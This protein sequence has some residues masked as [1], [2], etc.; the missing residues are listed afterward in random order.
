MAKYIIRKR[1][2]GNDLTGTKMNIPF[3]TKLD[4]IDLDGQPIIFHNDTPICYPTSQVVK[5]Y[6]VS[7]DDDNGE[8]RA[9]LINNIRN[10]LEKNDDK[11]QDRWDKLWEDETASNFR[12]KELDDHWLWSTEFYSAPIIALQHIFGLIKNV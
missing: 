4:S 1:Y 5:D 2:T 8:L 11:H 9:E 10:I 3:G 12:N 7:D 6:M